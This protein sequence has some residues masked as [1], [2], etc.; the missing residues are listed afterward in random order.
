MK[1][2]PVSFFL[3]FFNRKITEKKIKHALKNDLSFLPFKD[4]LKFTQCQWRSSNT[5]K[6]I[7][8]YFVI[9][10]FFL[11]FHVL[12]STCWI[13]IFWNS[14]I[15][16]NLWRQYIYDK[17]WKERLESKITSFPSEF[18][19]HLFGPNQRPL[20]M[21]QWWSWASWSVFWVG[22]P[23]GLHLDLFALLLQKQR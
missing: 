12:H 16:S 3:E 8:R 10:R 15:D 2:I 19:C 14:N 11:V 22:E 21:P 17:R 9:V 13:G 5:G 23:S 20:L 6:H 1:W 4:Q 7:S 18:Q